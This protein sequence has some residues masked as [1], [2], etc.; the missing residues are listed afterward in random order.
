LCA[1]Q[2]HY[3][4]DLTRLCTQITELQVFDHLRR[5]EGGPQGG[6][7]A[8]SFRARHLAASSSG[9]AARC[10]TQSDRF[11]LRARFRAG[12]GAFRVFLTLCTTCS[13]RTRASNS[14]AVS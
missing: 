1:D 3:L 6:G 10:A 9:S 2:D 8:T 4:G 14:S 11:A 12:V 13:V 5:L 7:S